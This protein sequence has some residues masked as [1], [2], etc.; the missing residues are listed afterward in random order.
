MAEKGL[1][2]MEKMRSPPI[3]TG[4]DTAYQKAFRVVFCLVG[5]EVRTLVLSNGLPPRKVAVFRAAGE[6]ISDSL[7]MRVCPSS[8]SAQKSVFMRC[9]TLRAASLGEMLQPQFSRSVN[10]SPADW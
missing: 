6:E 5:D 3:K 10:S 4:V 1:S 9:A 7:A 2:P 8:I